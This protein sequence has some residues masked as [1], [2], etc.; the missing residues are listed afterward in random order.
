MPQRSFTDF[1][2]GVLACASVLGFYV[3]L[4]E[5]EAAAD[6]RRRQARR[7]AEERWNLP[8]KRKR[9][10]TVEDSCRHCSGSGDC[11]SC[12]PQPCRIC[13]GAGLQPRDATLVP[14][15]T[16]LWDGAAFD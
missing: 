3:V 11:L 2:V 8:L 10:R 1:I 5:S 12:A 13:K 15:L 9:R 6:E 14:R 16:A 4:R 7:F